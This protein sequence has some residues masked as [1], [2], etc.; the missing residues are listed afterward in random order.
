[1]GG[2]GKSCQRRT[3]HAPVQQRAPRVLRG[4][5]D[6]LRLA[7]VLHDHLEW[8]DFRNRTPPHRLLRASLAESTGMNQAIFAE[9]GRRQ[10]AHDACVCFAV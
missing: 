3:L 4:Q 7:I 10:K 2:W 8:H 6:T 1:M 5:P 9:G